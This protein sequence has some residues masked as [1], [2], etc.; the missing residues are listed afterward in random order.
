VPRRWSRTTTGN[1]PVAA[2]RTLWRAIAAV[3]ACRCSPWSHQRA[4][5]DAFLRNAHAAEP[6]ADDEHT[7]VPCSPVPALLS[8]RAG[9]ERGQIVVQS[10]ADRRCS[11]SSRRGAALVTLPGRRAMGARVDPAGLAELVSQRTQ[12]T[13][14]R[15]R[16]SPF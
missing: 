12:K 13:G 4:D 2:H 5:V 14:N 9:F 7:E 3:H 11:I 1:S 15:V 10:A 16:S 8:R 6:R